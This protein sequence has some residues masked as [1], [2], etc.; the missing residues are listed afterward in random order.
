MNEF[1][2]SCPHCQQNIQATPEYAGV[3]INCPSCQTP[4][5]VPNAQVAAAPPKQAKLSMAASTVQ[6]AA[7][8]PVMATTMVRKT[9]KPRVGLYV[10][11]GVGAVAIVAAIIFVPKALDK[12]Q[13]HKETVA[14]KELAAKTPPPPPEPGVDEILKKVDEVYKGLTSYSAQGDSI[15]TM[16]M[17]AISPILKGP[18]TMTSKLSVLLG[19]PNFYRIEWERQGGPKTIKGAAWSSGKGDYVRTANVPTKYKSRDLALTMAGASSGTLGASVAE[20]FFDST[21]SLATGLKNS[22]KTK[23]ETINGHKCY[24]VSGQIAFQNLQFWI[25]KDDFMI[26][27]IKVT[28]GGKIDDSMLAGLTPTQKA[29]MQQASKIKGDIVETYQDIE[30]NKVLNPGDFET[31]FTPNANPKPKQARGPRA[32]A[33]AAAGQPQ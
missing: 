22:S 20:L 1:K 17:S 11:L 4:I 23:N 31:A 30:T 13:Q 16:D 6:H 8:S 21:N 18:Q 9:K 10:G 14:A 26:A 32:S 7:T 29:Q 12:Y 33:R 5:V 25:E 28:L 15:G 27:Q 19:K 24:V 2:F 3:Q